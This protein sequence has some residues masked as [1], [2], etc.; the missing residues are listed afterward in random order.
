MKGYRA[1]FLLQGGS[2]A[3]YDD[4]F[5]ETSKKKDVVIHLSNSVL[6]ETVFNKIVDTVSWGATESGK[7]K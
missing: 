7:K 6:D 1:K 2:P 5:F 4:I 3:P